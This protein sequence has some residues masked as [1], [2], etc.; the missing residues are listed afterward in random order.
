[1]SRDRVISAKAKIRDESLRFSVR[2]EQ[3]PLLLSQGYSNKLIA[4]KLDLSIDTV[5][6]E[7]GEHPLFR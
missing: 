6:R 3:I 1:M 2:K 7:F 4:S 5:C